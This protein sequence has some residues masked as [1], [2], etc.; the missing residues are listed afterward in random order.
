MTP[1]SAEELHM[2][3]FGEHRTTS[4]SP[5]LLIL[6]DDTRTV[7]V[8]TRALQEKMSSLVV[9]TCSSPRR[10]RELL[11]TSSSHAIIA[12]PILNLVDGVSALTCSQRIQ[13][14]VPLLMTLSADEQEV[15]P[16]WLDLGVYDFIFSPVDPSQVLESVQ[17]AILLSKRRA[18]ILQREQALHRLRQRRE[19]YQIN[20]A[21]SPIRNEV[22]KLLK[23]SIGRLEQSVESLTQTAKRIEASLQRLQQSCHENELRARQ[24]ALNGLVADLTR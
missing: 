12:S 15:A 2:G 24:R 20:F 22:D 9:E 23:E 14:A 17:Q 3:S 5:R 6:H 8:I 21:D 18:V 4:E 19:R 7:N 1:S 10:V 13:P 11:S 16:N